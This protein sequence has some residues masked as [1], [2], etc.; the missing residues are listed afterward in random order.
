MRPYSGALHLSFGP[1]C[2]SIDL[3][4]KSFHVKEKQGR[5][6]TAS[7]SQG[8]NLISWALVFPVRF[9]L[10]CNY[11]LSWCNTIILKTLRSQCVRQW[12]VVVFLLV[13][14]ISRFST[15]SQHLLSK[16]SGLMLTD[17]GRSHQHIN[18]PSSQ[19][20]TNPRLLCTACTADGWLLTQFA[21]LVEACKFTG[22]V[23]KFYTRGS[24]SRA[25][26]LTVSCR[27]VKLSLTNCN[28]LEKGH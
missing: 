15:K 24:W 3:L 8:G 26:S 19:P 16:S 2:Y 4:Q 18:G 23:S 5:L 13:N 10:L 20:I 1:V 28:F 9:C 17:S 22:T 21:P 27:W 6:Y 12:G 14:I 7:S 25:V 11:L